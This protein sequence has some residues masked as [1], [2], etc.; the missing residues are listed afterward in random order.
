MQFPDFYQPGRVGQLYQPD[1]PGAIERGIAL[2][3][4]PAEEDQRRQMLLLVDCQVDFIHPQGSLSVPGAVDD[5]QR[6][7]VWIF[8]NLGQLT[9]IAASLDSHVPNQIFYPTWWVTDD[10]EH[11]APYTVITSDEVTSGQW[12]PIYEPE[13]SVDYVRRLETQAKK[14]LMIWPYH[15]MIGSPGHNLM[16]ALYEAV[17]YHAAARQAQPIFLPKGT[18]PKTENY[19]ILEPEV[20]VPELP[21]GQLNTGFLDMMAGYDRVYITGQAKSHCVLETVGS[22]MRYFADQPDA[23]D[24]FHVLMD[25]T[26]SVAHPQIDFEALATESYQ[27][28]AAQGLHLAKST[29]PLD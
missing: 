4:A 28:F 27:A 16:P 6:T 19:S 29:D 13:W 10:G 3:V 25:C 23:I 18:I 21:Q 8:R 20:K 1:I 15:T 17:V 26:S 11:P 14:Q 2:D 22:I 7:V 9:T 5:T 12:T 24:R